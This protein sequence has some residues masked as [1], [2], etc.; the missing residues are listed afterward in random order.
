MCGE[1]LL[2]WASAANRAGS[3]RSS[4]WLSLR[5]HALPSAGSCWVSMDCWRFTSEMSIL[6]IPLLGG[7][8]PA[9]GFQSLT[10]GRS[11]GPENGAA[12]CTMLGLSS[13]CSFSV[14]AL[15]LLTD[16]ALRLPQSFPGDSL[17]ALCM[18]VFACLQSKSYFSTDTAEQES[19]RVYSNQNI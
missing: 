11:G 10:A 8:S 17:M 7:S 6:N 2:G 5:A 4:R 1:V 3:G 13:C 9:Q 12:R 16:S 14:S 19:P 15:A 18:G